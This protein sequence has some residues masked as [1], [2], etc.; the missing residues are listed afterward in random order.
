MGVCTCMRDCACARLDFFKITV[1]AVACVMSG[2]GRD[3]TQTLFQFRAKKINSNLNYC[4]QTARIEF[5]STNNDPIGLMDLPT[6]LN[7][8]ANPQ[9]HR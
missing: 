2:Q 7:A 6:F 8:Y 9:H 5:K 1:I 4:R 3:I